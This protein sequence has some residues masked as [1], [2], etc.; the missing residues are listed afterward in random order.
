[1]HRKNRFYLFIILILIILGGFFF[2]S[3]FIDERRQIES[4]TRDIIPRGS[5]SDFEKATISIFNAAAPSVVYIFT[6]NAVTGFFGTRQIRQGA[7]SGAA[8]RDRGD[9]PHPRRRG[10]GGGPGIGASLRLSEG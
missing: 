7:G 4:H 8:V 1:M 5:L 6:E 2:W 10:R 9:L 3:R